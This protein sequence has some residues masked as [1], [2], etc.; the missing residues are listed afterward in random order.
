MQSNLKC[1]ARAS[2]PRAMDATAKGPSV[3]AL[4]ADGRTLRR[5]STVRLPDEAPL[6]PTFEAPA[7]PAPPAKQETWLPTKAPPP[8]I[9]AAPSQ[10][11]APP[12]G[13][14][15]E[16]SQFKAPPP[17]VPAKKCLVIAA[18]PPVAPAADPVAAPLVGQ[19]DEA[20]LPPLLEA[21]EPSAPPA[22]Q[23]AEPLTKAPPP[24]LGAAPKQFRAPPPEHAYYVV[25]AVPPRPPVPAAG[26]SVAPAAHPEADAPTVISCACRQRADEIARGL[27]ALR[28]ITQRHDAWDS[29][30]SSRL[31]RYRDSDGQEWQYDPLTYEWKYVHHVWA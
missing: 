2:Q 25:P 22:K 11:K 29:S 30:V 18:Q 13:I 12:P 17:E 20:P 24:G 21:P 26:P 6:P 7:P 28:G 23:E 27:R 10:F 8:G 14:S 5:N 1:A 16:P 31:E 3:V 9:S 19:P 15:A 4:L